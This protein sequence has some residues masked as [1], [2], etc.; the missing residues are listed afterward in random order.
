MIEILLKATNHLALIL[1][2]EILLAT[3]PENHNRNTAEC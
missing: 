3:I 2:N 1:L